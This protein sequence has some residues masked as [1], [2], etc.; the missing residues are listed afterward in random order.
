MRA[1][2]GPG[3]HGGGDLFGRRGG[4]SDGNDDAGRGRFLDELHRI[5]GFRGQGHQ[6]NAVAGDLLKFGELRPI[7]GPHMLQRMCPARAVFGGYV[8]PFEMAAGDHFL[9]PSFPPAGFIDRLE[10]RGEG[11][12]G[13]GDER[14]AHPRDAIAKM[15]P[16]RF[17]HI[18]RRQP[19][20]A[21]PGPRV[22]V[23]LQIKQP[24]GN[25]RPIGDIALRKRRLHR[26]NAIALDGDAN[27]FP[28]L[29]PPPEYLH[30]ASFL[31]RDRH[32]FQWFE[33]QDNKKFVEE[34]RS[35]EADEFLVT[36]IPLTSCAALSFTPLRLGVRFL[37]ME[38][39]MGHGA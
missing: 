17:E 19:L 9:G 11:F 5:L 20:F 33:R 3:I 31:L 14:G 22:P 18:I 1:E 23:N 21:E 26:P 25:P 27:G 32:A 30:D 12:K 39:P 36:L 28:I 13:I 7:R 2:P 34:P 8:R 15:R 24:R 10:T 38:S 4:V 29:I 6:A 16:K 35:K 37:L